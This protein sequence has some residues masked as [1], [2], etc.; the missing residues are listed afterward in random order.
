MTKNI[1]PEITIE[2]IA[3]QSL[4]KKQDLNTATSPDDSDH[5]TIDQ[6]LTA[7]EQGYVNKSGGVWGDNYPIAC[8]E[9][10]KKVTY[11]LSWLEASKLAD[12]VREKKV[13]EDT[14]TPSQRGRLYASVV[15]SLQ[16]LVKEE[17]GSGAVSQTQNNLSLDDQKRY[18][19][20]IVAGLYLLRM[21]KTPTCTELFNHLLSK[22]PILKGYIP[23]VIGRYTPDD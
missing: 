12:K 16:L 1:N 5:L 13:N 14:L 18:C 9:D 22:K 21:L 15:R 7:F 20:E 4:P 10:G 3:L 6:Y 19:T 11:S 8:Q 23:E 2:I 17:I